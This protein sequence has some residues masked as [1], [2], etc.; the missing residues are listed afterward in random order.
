VFR[1]VGAII[2]TFHGSAGG[3]ASSLAHDLIQLWLSRTL[4]VGSS[5]LSALYDR[6]SVIYDSRSLPDEQ[7]R[8]NAA[9][10]L[11]EFL[12]RDAARLPPG[13]V[14]RHLTA[15][16]NLAGRDD[17]TLQ[18]VLE[19]ALSALEAG[20]ADDDQRKALTLIATDALSAAR[21][22]GLPATLA[23]WLTLHG[24]PDEY[25]PLFGEEP[26]AFMAGAAGSQVRETHPA[27]FQRALATMT[28]R[29][30]G[31]KEGYSGHPVE[32]Q[33]NYR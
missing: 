4:A 30:P 23:M 22:R 24:H 21:S 19:G 9:K 28:A 31:I 29:Y 11:L 14:I 3:R 7:T 6:A 17:L 27:L 8:A 15:A 32:V 20:Q 25:A 16:M 33:A 13:T 26:E 12:H 5:D 10:L 2:T 18:L 1:A